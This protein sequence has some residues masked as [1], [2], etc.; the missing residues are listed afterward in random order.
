M[1]DSPIAPLLRQLQQQQQQQL[2][3]QQ[4]VL[5]IFEQHIQQT[6]KQFKELQDSFD[7]LSQQTADSSWEART[8]SDRSERQSL[9]PV[10][11]LRSRSAAPL[12]CEANPAAVEAFLQCE[13]G[14]IQHVERQRDNIR[15]KQRYLVQFQTAA[16]A[17]AAYGAF[18]GSSKAAAATLDIK[19]TRLQ[20]TLVDLAI[21][22]Q[23]VARV[24]CG[25]GEELVVLARGSYLLVKLGAREPV[26][27]PCH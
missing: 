15:G 4:Q 26:L 23:R 20:N 27:Y 12:P 18:K 7:Q 2:Q 13:R 17:A 9:Y 11:L 22:L 1:A 21:Q 5:N 14:S 10:R 19:R 6:Q 8:T 16:A 24:E 25:W 3:Q